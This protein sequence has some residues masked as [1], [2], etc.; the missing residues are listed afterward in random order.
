MF[1][2]MLFLIFRNSFKFKWHRF[3][4]KFLPQNKPTILVQ[5]KTA[6][7]EKGLQSSNL[8][9]MISSHFFLSLSLSHSLC[10]QS[11]NNY[12]LLH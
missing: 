7:K 10:N 11:I 8:Q 4:E 9:I 3:V 6:D 12:L 2:S 1:N 5:M